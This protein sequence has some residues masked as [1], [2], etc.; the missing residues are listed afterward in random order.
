[1]SISMEV[2]QGMGREARNRVPFDE[3]SSTFART[4]G[5]CL[6]SNIFRMAGRF[7]LKRDSRFCCTCHSSAERGN[8]DRDRCPDLRFCQPDKE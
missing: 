8:L 4:M 6:R 3:M 2:P 1:M 7:G 5:L